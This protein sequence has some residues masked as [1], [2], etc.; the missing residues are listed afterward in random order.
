[1]ELVEWRE[2]RDGKQLIFGC[3]HRERRRDLVGE[4]SGAIVLAHFG[5]GGGGIGHEGPPGLV[6]YRKVPMV[7]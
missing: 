7:I 5:G 1:M 6:G 3:D 4:A 2:L